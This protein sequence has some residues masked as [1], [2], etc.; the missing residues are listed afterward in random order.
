MSR[1]ILSARPCSRRASR[2]DS[3]HAAFLARILRLHALLVEQR[4]I[5]SVALAAELGVNERTIKRDIAYMRD[6]LGCPIAWRAA[7]HSYVYTAPCD[8]LPLLRLSADEALSLALAGRTFSAWGG[9]A[10]GEALTAALSKIAQVVGGSVSLPA[11]AVS[12]LVFQPP[13]HPMVDHERRCFAIVLEAIHRCREL[14]LEY[15]KPRSATAEHRTVHPLH[16]AFLDHEWVVLAHDCRRGAVR[17]FR[18]SRIRRVQHT[19]GRFEP[20]AGFRLEEHLAG[21][22][23][24]FTGDGDWSIRLKIDA[25]IVPYVEERP[26]HRSQVLQR[27]ADGGAEMTLRLNNLID[28]QRRVLACGSHVEVLE[29]AELREA[30]AREVRLLAARYEA[31]SARVLQAAENAGNYSG[32][33]VL[34][35]PAC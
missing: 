14:R 33:R 20:P 7:E 13:E 24:R 23:G 26:W 28:I 2:P 1:F 15:K 6:S 19:G 9:S 8:I 4:P 21:S 17:T 25:I 5:T 18:L 16:L 22:V 29:P 27:T 34:S 10:L 11:D 30:V 12:G 31:D 35:S 32:G 3:P